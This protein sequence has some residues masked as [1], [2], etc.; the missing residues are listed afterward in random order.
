[1]GKHGVAAVILAVVVVNALIGTF[2]EGRAERSMAALRV[3]VIRGGEEVS[4]EARE[5]VPGDLLM[6]AAG[7]AVGADARLVEA[8]ALEAAEAALT[9]E[10][11]PVVKQIESLPE[12][13]LLADRTNMLYSGTHITAGRGRA[14]VVATGLATEVG[15]IARMTG[16]AEEPPTPLELRIAQVGRYLVVRRYTDIEVHE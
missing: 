12:D 2:Q 16:S 10:S 3:H 13:T 7:D 8:T 14:V 1:M 5:L 11:L 4:V 6:L 15:Q 9:G